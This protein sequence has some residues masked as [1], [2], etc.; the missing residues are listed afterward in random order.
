MKTIALGAALALTAMSWPVFA[1][2]QSSAPAKASVEE[3]CKAMGEQHGM[4]GDK[5]DSWMKKCLE[6]SKQMHDGMDMG[7]Q[8]GAND[9]QNNDTQNNDDMEDPEDGDKAM[10]GGNNK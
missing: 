4:T 8:S 10:G 9:T 3:Q 5:M 2:R 7:E 1:E 6:V